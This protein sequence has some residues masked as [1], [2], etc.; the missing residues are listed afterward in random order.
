LRNYKT[1]YEIKEY[2]YKKKGTIKDKQPFDTRQTFGDS[3]SKKEHRVIYQYSQD[4]AKLNNR[5]IDK[6]LKKAQEQKAGNAKIKKAK[7]LK[8]VK[9]KKEIDYEAVEAAHQMAEIKGYVT[10]LTCDE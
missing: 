3:N 5:N 7:F 9:S 6:Q 1:P 8:I 10:N 2:H 4:R